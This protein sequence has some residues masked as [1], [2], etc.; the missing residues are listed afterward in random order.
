M[1]CMSA[2]T[3]SAPATSPLAHEQSSGQLHVHEREPL[4]AELR[5]KVA[6]LEGRASANEYTEQLPTHA[7]LSGLIELQRGASYVVD[8]ASLAILLMAGPS[9]GGAWCAIIGSAE[10]SL[11]AAAA[12]GV[13]LER[14][15]VIPSPA[16]HWVEVLAALIDAVQV[17]V[18]RPRQLVEESIAARLA[19][20]LRDR[21]GV[22]V[23]WGQWPRAHA[24]L[25][26]TESSWR[27]VGQG[28]GHLQARQVT[29]AA[30]NGGKK[31]QS[32]QLWLP[33]NNQQI[34]LVSSQDPESGSADEP[35]TTHEL[36]HVG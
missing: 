35:G 8:H 3:L 24:Q 25:T 30:Q 22:L 15:I 12:A 27:G 9:A 13:N 21:G 6:R 32:R 11:P 5:E 1:G 34:R 36:R 26:I 14:T 7:A 4:I 20:R 31:N 18:I 23:S 28:H 10:I 2:S 19:A 29:V 17:V 16:E 33:D